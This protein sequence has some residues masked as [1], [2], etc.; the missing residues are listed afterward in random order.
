MISLYNQKLCLKYTYC[1]VRGPFF[2]TVW[3]NCNYWLPHHWP[4]VQ[5]NQKLI[6]WKFNVV[7]SNSLS[8]FRLAWI[9]SKILKKYFKKVEKNVKSILRLGDFV[10]RFQTQFSKNMYCLITQLKSLLNFP[11]L[12]ILIEFRTRT[13][14]ISRLL[15]FVHTYLMKPRNSLLS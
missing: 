9:V 10:S 7:P 3:L 15:N 12:R 13:M 8:I 14:I 11:L 5:F 2:A 1:D 4:N 6:T